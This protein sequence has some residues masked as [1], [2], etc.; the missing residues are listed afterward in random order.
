MKRTLF[1]LLCTVCYF[2]SFS[3]DYYEGQR[4]SWLQKA[5]SN[6]P[7]LMISEHKPKA[8]VQI[9]PDDHAFQGWKAQALAP[10]DSLYQASFKSRSGVVVDFGEH[11]TGYFSFRIDTLAGTPDAHLRFRCTFGEVPSEIATPFDPYPGGLSRA[12]LQDEVVTVTE[13]PALITIPRRVAFRYVKIEL[14][15]SSPWFDVKLSEMTCRAQ[16]SARETPE[17]LPASVPE[18]FRKID[19]VGLNTLKEC[20]QTVYEDGAKRDQRLWLGDLYLESLANIHSYKQHDLTRRCL[21]LLAGISAPDG[22]L[23]ATAFEK[24]EPHP[25]ESQLF[26]DYA[27][28]F[29]VAL[30]DYYEATQDMETAKDLWIVAKKQLDVVPEYLTADGLMDYAKA[31]EKW[32]IFFDWNDQLYKEIALQGITIYA[33]EE[34]YRL[35]KLLGMEKEVS[36]YPA[37]IR[38]MRSAA[39]KA[40]YEKK[41]GLFIH[42]AHRQVSYT[43]QVW[44]VLGG[45]VTGRE[46]QQ[47]LK[48]LP[49]L[50]DV[51]K[52][53]TPYAYHYY[54]QA[55]IHCGLQAEV[56]QAVETYWGG[57]VKKGA[58]TFW[59]INDPENEFLSPYGF[60]PINSYC[61]AWSCTPVYF[62]R[63][64][65]AIFAGK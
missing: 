30:K 46:A 65:P 63:K 10:A 18:I 9:V 59:E 3:R 28:L 50:P 38:Q 21:Y 17:E 56:R 32:T 26:L 31:D 54:I 44:M 51:C 1:L 41:T 14:L 47:A 25:Q 57:M 36:A 2:S 43:S 6:I 64:Y 58:D 62:I 34:T 29:N 48:V 16:T 15:G 7:H 27:L 33:L 61:H 20:M 35:A 5:K 55:L 49:T 39:R 42:P 23:F 37:W 22:Y 52:P 11:L 45:V 4:T 13:I 8:L 40:W 24:P 53:G 12:W 19:Q 60:F